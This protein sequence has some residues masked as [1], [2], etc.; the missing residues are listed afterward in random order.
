MNTGN[1]RPW[2]KTNFNHFSSTRCKNSNERQNK[3]CN[4][5][6]SPNRGTLCDRYWCQWKTK[7]NPDGM[8]IEQEFRALVPPGRS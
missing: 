2:A 5:I 8:I 3:Q 7:L 6:A 1:C 4:R